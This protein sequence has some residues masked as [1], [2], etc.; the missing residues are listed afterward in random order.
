MNNNDKILRTEINKMIGKA[1]IKY[2]LKYNRF[3]LAEKLGT[4]NLKPK[5]KACKNY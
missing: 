4:Q 1:K 5:Q 3:E 2:Y